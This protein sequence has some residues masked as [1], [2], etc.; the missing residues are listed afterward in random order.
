MNANC[1][2]GKAAIANERQFTVAKFEAH[3]AAADQ[4][5]SNDEKTP[6]LGLVGE[7]GSLVSALKK[8]RRDTDGFLGYH[9]TVVEELG[10]VL[11]YISTVARRGGCSLS[12]TVARVVGGGRQPETVTFEG[13]ASTEVTVELPAFDVA[14]LRLAGEAGDLSKRFVEGAYV[15]NVDALRGDL[16][17]LTR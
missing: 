9:A 15:K 17:K 2:I 8:K 11:W 5:D 12:E 7:V 16:V 13:L 14:L 6:F 3:A 1:T 10:D 4:L